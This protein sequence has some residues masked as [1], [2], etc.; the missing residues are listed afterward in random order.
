MRAP[1]ESDALAEPNGLPRSGGSSSVRQADEALQGNTSF[2]ERVNHLGTSF[3][4]GPR[5]CWHL[6]SEGVP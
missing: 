1:G 5:L 4:R 3:I 6:S 2:P